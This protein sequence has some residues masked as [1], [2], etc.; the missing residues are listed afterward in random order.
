MADRWL[1]VSEAAP[2]FGGG[3]M[4]V[5]RRIWSGELEAT[6][7]AIEGDKPQY[8]VRESAIAKYFESRIIRAP[9]RGLA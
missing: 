2:L 6:N 4:R 8:R 3:V 5:Y 7:V 9:K 1:S